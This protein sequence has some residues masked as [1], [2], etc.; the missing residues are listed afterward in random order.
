[1]RQTFLLL[2]VLSFAGWSQQPAQ[3]PAQALPPVVR[4]EMPPTNA[5]NLWMLAVPAL[6]GAL[7]AWIG[8]WLTNRNNRR[9]WDRQ[10]TLAAKQEH[11]EKVLSAVWKE[12]KLLAECWDALPTGNGADSETVKAINTAQREGLN[13]TTVAALY[14]SDALFRVHSQ[15]TT[16][17][18]RLAEAITAPSN[19]GAANTYFGEYNKLFACFINIARAELGYKEKLHILRP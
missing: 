11:Y 5:P 12:G 2:T 1:M 18:A 6:V 16:A 19:F 8:V 9:Q 13:A 4:V 10:A 15:L 17:S 14:M 7:S 3:Q